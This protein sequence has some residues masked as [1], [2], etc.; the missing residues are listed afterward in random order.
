MGRREITTAVTMMALIA[1]LI[2]GAV[3]GWRSLFAPLP[4]EAVVA[5]EPAPTC[6]SEQIQPGQR[7][8]SAQVRVSVLN[9]SNRSGLAGSTLDKLLNRGFIAGEA[10]NAPEGVNVRRVQVRTTER[11][12]PRARLVA[13]QFGKNLKPQVVEEDLG[14]GVDVVLGDRFQKLVKAPRGIE[15]KQRQEICVPIPTAEPD[16]D[17]DTNTDAQG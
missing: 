7:I 2:V 12:D 5:E 6:T 4:E 11:N 16:P 3:W 8:R 13:R 15:V 10:A 14:P 17:A 9:A 1:M